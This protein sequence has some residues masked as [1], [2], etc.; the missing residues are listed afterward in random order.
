M[1]AHQEF[2]PTMSIGL[3]CWK[4]AANPHPGKAHVQV[5]LWEREDRHLSL[6][7]TISQHLYLCIVILH[8]DEKEYR[9]WQCHQ[10]KQD[11]L[12]SA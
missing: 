2:S 12:Y 9:Q 10:G 8:G 3:I 6:G 4:E 7:Q 1:S 11:H 5:A